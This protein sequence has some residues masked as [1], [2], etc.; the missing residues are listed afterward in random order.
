MTKTVKLTAFVAVSLL[1]AL[2]SCESIKEKLAVTV[3]INDRE[4]VFEVGTNPTAAPAFKA[5]AATNAVVLL[6][7]TYD[8]NVE[9]EAKKLGY[10]MDNIIEF[11]LSAASI[12][13]IEPLDFNL[14]E[15]SNIK[16][17]FDDQTKLVAQVDKIAN[18]KITIKIVNDDLLQKLKA[19]QLHVI[20]TGDNLPS[21]RVKL[22]L[23]TSYKAKINVFK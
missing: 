13:L 22:K 10:D 1:F 20:I 19:D 9:S 5:P 23:I 21:K 8:V 2:T 11:V 12:E 14:N 18:G 15:F 6:D 4:L 16:L 3:P 17:Y 7:K